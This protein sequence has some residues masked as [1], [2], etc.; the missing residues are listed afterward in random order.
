MAMSSYFAMDLHLKVKHLAAALKVNSGQYPVNSGHNDG[1]RRRQARP[2]T[3][4][5]AS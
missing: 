1:N 4:P 3:L 5:A 2:A